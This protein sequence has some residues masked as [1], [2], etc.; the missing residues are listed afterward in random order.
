[1]AGRAAQLAPWPFARTASSRGCVAATVV[2]EG[3]GGAAPERGRPR[4]R[5][6]SR[7]FALPGEIVS[8]LSAEVNGLLRRRRDRTHSDAAF[9]ARA[10]RLCRQRRRP[11]PAL[12]R[13]SPARGSLTVIGRVTES[14]GQPPSCS[15]SR[16]PD[17][18]QVRCS[19]ARRLG[20][21][22]TRAR[23]GRREGAW[24][25]VATDPGLARPGAGPRSLRI[26][27]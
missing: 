20:G 8:S 15:H 14:F 7:G 16:G 21:R 22:R 11:L 1:M 25:E 3:V 4:T 5:G 23:S 2:V 24:Y 17:V 6:W 19:A 9:R 10:C 13:S 27:G 26:P 18:K 12:G